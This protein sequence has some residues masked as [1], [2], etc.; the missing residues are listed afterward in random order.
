MTDTLFLFD[1]DDTLTNSMSLGSQCFAQTYQDLF[2]I[3]QVSI[4]WSSYPHVTDWG[5]SYALFKSYLG[6]KPSKDDL[7]KVEK[8]YNRLLEN[9]YAAKESIKQVDGAKTFIN[10]LLENDIPVALATGGWSYSAHLKLSKAG[11][12][13]GHLPMG[14]SDDAWSRASI[15][16]KGVKKAS[17]YYSSTFDKVVYFGD[18]LWDKTTCQQLNIPLIGIDIHQ[19]NKLK[20][21]GLEY[22]FRDFL[23]PSSIFKAVEVLVK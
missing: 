1:I 2:G 4:D 11:Y 17:K 21:A 3:E 23:D 22:V 9:T 7:Q 16:E 12:S 6:R 19:N 5:L 10:Q 15:M 20:T 18:G 14:N 13:L 8:H